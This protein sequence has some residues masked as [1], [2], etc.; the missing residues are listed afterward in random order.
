MYLAFHA[1]GYAAQAAF[2]RWHTAGRL[3]LL[4]LTHVEMNRMATLMDKYQDRPMDLADASLIAVAEHRGFRHLFT[5]DSDFYIYRLLDGSVL[6]CFPE[7]P[8]R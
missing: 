2:W 4:D 8:T 6:K 1:G 7:H 5:L 3:A